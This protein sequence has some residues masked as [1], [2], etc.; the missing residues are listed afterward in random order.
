MHLFW[1]HGYESTSLALLKDA[2]GGISSPS[3]YAAFGSKEML[4]EEV[5]KQYLETHGTVT[6]VLHDP[7][8]APRDAV[9]AA[10]RGSARMQTDPLHP[11]GCLLV[12]SA[13]TTPGDA[14]GSQSILAMDRAST[15]QG[16]AAC[17]QRAVE[18]RELPGTFDVEAGALMLDTFMRGLTTQVRDGVAFAQLE[19]AIACAMHWWK[20]PRRSVRKS[21]H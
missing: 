3:F 8:V 14:V 10:L 7:S 18:A 19:A 5:L 11:P 12:I 20:P 21:A 17:I 9:E 4:F 1:A 2:M 13:T 15:R 16:F 6:A